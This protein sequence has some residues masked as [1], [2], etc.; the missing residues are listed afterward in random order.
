[1]EDIMNIFKIMLIAIITI[2]FGFAGCDSKPNRRTGLATSTTETT[3]SVNISLST[4][5]GGSVNGATVQLQNNANSSVNFSETATSSTV[6]FQNVPFGTYTLTITRTGYSQF[7]NNSLSVQ[8]A[9]ASSSVQLISNIIGSTGPAGGIIFYDKGFVSDGWRYL[10]AAPA[11]SEFNARWSDWGTNVDGTQLGI[12]TGK[13]NTELIVARMNQLGQTGT[14][15]QRSVA[16]NINGFT[17]WF[18]PSRDELNLMYQNRNM[19]GGFSN[20]WYWSS[21]QDGT[22]SAWFQH[23][24]SGNQVNYSKAN[25]NRVRGVRAF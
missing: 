4:S 9:T 6:I 14:A 3:A 16:L 5:D 22:D 2:L 23:F 24:F 1:M 12:G 25:A 18:L 17:D 8:S 10:E 7:V 21:S 15:A 20:S 19:I 13:R 11:S